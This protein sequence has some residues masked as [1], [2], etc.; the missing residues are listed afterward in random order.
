MAYFHHAAPRKSTYDPGKHD[1][2]WVANGFTVL[3]LLITLTIGMILIG[4]AVPAWM[5]ISAQNQLATS[6]NH[7]N[8]A[9]YFARQAAISF[10]APVTLCAGNAS[11]CFSATNWNWAKGWLAFIDRDHDGT[12]DT[13][14]KVLS[15]GSA[16]GHEV[17]VAGNTPFKKPLVFMPMGQGERVS[18]AFAAGRLR[19]CV[20]SAIENNARDLVLSISGRVR[21]ER[22][23]LH[24]HC[25]SP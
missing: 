8:R 13:G 16:F 10:N 12:L 3:E 17:V 18:G 23:D 21:V 4:I 11:G 9:L 22:V 5:H 25:S 14:E 19:V 15:T 24:G 2:A 6:A 1:P 20:P 7:F